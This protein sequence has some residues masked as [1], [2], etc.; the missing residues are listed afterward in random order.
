M[1]LQRRTFVRG[2]AA[3][4]LGAFVA[5]AGTAAAVAA[6]RP[7]RGNAGAGGP[8][9][10]LGPATSLDG[11]P[12][13]DYDFSR[14]NRLPA[15][16]TGYWEKSFDVGGTTR[17]AKVYISADT[18]IRA[19]YTVIAVPEGTDTASFLWKSGWRDIADSRDE[20]LFVLEPGPG[21]WASAE[22]ER[23]YVDAAMAFYQSNRYFSI[24]GEHYL[25]GYDGG[26]APLEAW[27]VAHPLR[28]IAQAYLGSTGLPQ[29]Y[30]GSFASRTF[31]GTTDAGYTT[32]TFPEGFPLIRYDETV[33]PT[34]YIDPAASVDASLAYWRTANDTVP[35]AVRD[36]TLGRVW[37]QS[38]DSQR[39]MTSHAGPISQVAVSDRPVSYFNA[40]TTAQVDAFLTYYTRYENFFAY[41]NAL[42]E[43][44]DLSAPGVEIRTMLVDGDLR[45]YIVYVP[46]S[47]RQLWGSRAPVVFVWPGNT[48]T[49]RLFLDATDWIS[50]ADDGG[51][52][53]VVIGE[54]YS[55]SSVSVSHTDSVVFFQQLREVLLAEYDVD[56]TRF[57]STGQSAGSMVSQRFAIAM[58]EY[59]AAVAAT[60][61]GIA[62]TAAGTVNVEGVVYPA[63]NEPIPSYFVYGEG[64]LSNLRGTVWDGTTNTLDQM[65][66]YHLA[67]NGLTLDDVEDRQGVVSGFQDRLRTWEWHQPGTDVP[68][69]RLTLNEFRSHNT[70]PEE[71]PLLWDF[72]K[73][74]RSEIAP[75]GQVVR[76]YSPSGFTVAGD[77]TQILP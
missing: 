23:Q 18:P 35:T 47:A 53:L 33:L 5:H 77:E 2:T 50:V 8:S 70:I 40:R 69:Y 15:E 34:W 74:Y 75:D 14:A 59:F 76:W 66:A 9:G 25:V 30:L 72:L 61:G 48:Q 64:D 26:A 55:A 12:F 3:A 16:M 28:V 22:V 56:P 68:V 11:R 36:Q 46:A 49:A 67:N 52:V 19:Y 38:A 29:D 63:A 65:V 4:A 41:G 51:A 57:Y 73:S 37:S 44:A 7:D 58:P 27:A 21:G 24:F 60:S 6:P 71:T 20:G 43:R 17:T 10:K 54:Q 32:V 31:D 1:T 39:W 13:P 45:E 62:P 42:F